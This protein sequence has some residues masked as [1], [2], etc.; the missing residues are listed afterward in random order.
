MADERECD[1][2]VI[3][4]GLSGLSAAVHLLRQ[5]N[6]K[7]S[8]VILVEASNRV[9]GRTLSLPIPK[10]GV[11]IDLGGQWVGP[12]HY[13]IHKLAKRYNLKL[14]NQYDTGKKV[15]DLKGKITTYKG[16]IPDGVGLF[17]LL[18]LHFTLRK[19]EKLRLQLRDW[20]NYN[21]GILQKKEKK[22]KTT[23]YNEA[24]CLNTQLAVHNNLTGSDAYYYKKW[25]G[26]TCLS[27]INQNCWTKATK[28]LF[29]SAIRGV[30]GVEL[31]ELSFLSFLI[32]CNANGGIEPLISIPNGN[33]ERLFFQ[34]S[35]QL[36]EHLAKDF[37]QMNGEIL[38][39][40][41]VQSITTTNINEKTAKR[42]RV[43]CSNEVTLWTH[44]VIVAVPPAIAGKIS[45]EP[46]LSPMRERAL[47]KN[48]MGSIIKAIAFYNS[49]FWR[50][51]GFSGEVVSDSYEGPI[52][53]VYDKTTPLDSQP[54]KEQPALVIFINGKP[55][56]ESSC[57]ETESERKFLV[58]KQL[59][60]WFGE[61]ALEPIEYVEKD[62]VRDPWSCG[63]P[64]GVWPSGA[65]SLIGSILREPSNDN[66]IFWAAT[67]TAT[68]STGFMDGA[69]QS[70]E[71]AAD[72]LLASLNE[73][74]AANG[75]SLRK[76]ALLAK[77]EVKAERAKQLK[78]RKPWY[79]RLLIC[80]I[81]YCA[82]W[83]F[84]HFSTYNWE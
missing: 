64:I 65:L 77:R 56:T 81:L 63:C 84:L 57:Y 30:F 16:T 25:D 11:T 17:S 37:Q 72:Q 69:V 38:F 7:C 50:T 20:S 83:I 47:Q 45:F 19:V 31:E 58:L 46:R 53:N 24:E 9:G 29:E 71:R 62:W 8:K 70:G 14:L 2:V 10:L 68:R 6:D 44:R 34:G 26:Q 52:F 23:P 21:H 48:F 13:N 42:I 39:N 41:P 1:V 76:Q 35:Q 59:A 60:K 15:L 3:G 82:V 80:V 73:V 67:E 27:W 79:V 36:S 12:L 32:Y 5:Q 18:D 66:T 75:H 33:Q 28:L 55:A 22:S 43:S 61:E 51:K 4:G 40:S 74:G 78:T 49:P 54:N